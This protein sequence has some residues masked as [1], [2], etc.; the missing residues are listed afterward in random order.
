MGFDIGMV[1]GWLEAILEKYPL[2]DAVCLD[3]IDTTFEAIAA[4]Q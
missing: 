3:V 1:Y 2:L 4:M